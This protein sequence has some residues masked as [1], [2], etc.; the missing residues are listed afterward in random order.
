M[1]YW[2]ITFSEGLVMQ[3]AWIL[4]T[5]S[6]KHLCCLKILSTRKIRQL[7]MVQNCLNWVY[8]RKTNPRSQWNELPWSVTYWTLAVSTAA[9]M[10]SC[11]TATKLQCSECKAGLCFSYLPHKVNFWIRVPLTVWEGKHFHKCK[12]STFGVMYI[13]WSFYELVNFF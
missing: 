7:Q 13:V 3:E 1:K 9:L 11:I 4:K 12:Y 8:Q 5:A 2:K 6:V 10:V